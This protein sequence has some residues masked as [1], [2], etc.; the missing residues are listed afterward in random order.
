MNR[1]RRKSKTCL[2]KVSGCMVHNLCYEKGVLQ[3][4]FRALCPKRFHYWLEDGINQVVLFLEEKSAL[5]NEGLFLVFEN[6]RF[7][8][9]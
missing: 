5:K 6:L 8:N 2:A 3:I 7:Y 1:L 9:T 4:F